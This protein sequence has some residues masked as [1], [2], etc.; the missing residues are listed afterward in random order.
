MDLIEGSNSNLYFSWFFMYVRYTFEGGVLI[1]MWKGVLCDTI[2][3]YIM[4]FDIHKS[5][6]ST[7][8]ALQWF[9]ME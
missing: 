1:L 3:Y 9:N 2:S 6:Y 5:M 4:P 8:A 7:K